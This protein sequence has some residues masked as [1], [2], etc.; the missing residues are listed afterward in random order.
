MSKHTPG[1]WE[2]MTGSRTGAP[3]GLRAHGGNVVNFG[4]IS[5]ACSPEGK[6]NARLIAA[7]PELLYAL[8]VLADAVEDDQ[9]KAPMSKRLMSLPR[10]LELAREALAKAEGTA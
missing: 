10:A 2:Y 5:R 4:G 9:A 8:A 1:P 7:A 6:A 3:R